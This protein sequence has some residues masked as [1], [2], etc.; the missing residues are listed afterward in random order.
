MN[1]MIVLIPD[2]EMEARKSNFLK[3]T[4]LICDSNLEGPAR[5]PPQ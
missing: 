1:T 4:Q 5:N 2:E 3:F